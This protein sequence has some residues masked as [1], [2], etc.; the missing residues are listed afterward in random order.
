MRTKSSAFELYSDQSRSDVGGSVRGG[1]EGEVLVDDADGHRALADGGGDAL[2]RAGAAVADGEDTGEAGLE[3]HRGAAAV[4]RVGV[5]VGDVEGA[6]GDGAGVEG[7]DGG[8]PAG[9]KEAGVV[10]GQLAA[11]PLG[12]GVGADEDEEAADV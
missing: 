9:E 2:D 1:L 3:R 5:E 7:G 4:D 12:A 10:L 8:A 11:E 6:A